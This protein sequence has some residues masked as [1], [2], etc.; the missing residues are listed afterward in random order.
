MALM[1]SLVKLFR[2]FAIFS[3]KNSS[4]NFIL[5]PLRLGKLSWKDD[6][7]N[8]HNELKLCLMIT[9]STPGMLIISEKNDLQIS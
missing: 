2:C 7:M 4:W 5:Q 6:Q 8:S 3:L 1:T 9:L